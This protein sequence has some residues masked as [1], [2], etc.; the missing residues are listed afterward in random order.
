MADTEDAETLP[1]ANA[2]DGDFYIGL[3][4]SGYMT[5]S[6]AH[7][8]LWIMWAGS[9]GTVRAYVWADSFES[10]FEQFV[11]YLDD[12]APGLL[13]DVTEDDLREAAEELKIEWQDSWPDWE[14]AA[15]EP[16]ASQAEADLTSIGHTTLKHGQ[17]I[18]SWE[19]GGAPVTS[20][21]D[22]DIVAER[23]LEESDED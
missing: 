5:G 12:A 18:P 16:V 11:E 17:Y 7:E 21:R 8:G 13:T 3:D 2:G 22:W 4:D 14:D 15:F 9:V 10:A 6:E 20:G 1:I 23:S 19:W